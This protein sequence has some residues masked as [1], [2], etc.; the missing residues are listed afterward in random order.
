VHGRDAGRQALAD[1]GPVLAELGRPEVMGLT[2]E[3]GARCTPSS[4]ACWPP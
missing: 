1:A 4:S 2:A 3:E